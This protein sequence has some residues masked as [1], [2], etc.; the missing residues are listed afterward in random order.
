[1]EWWQLPGPASFVAKITNDLRDGKN[2]LVCLPN[3]VPNG[4]RAIIQSKLD[5]DI[6]WR[7][8]FI[9]TLDNASPMD[10]LHDLF[11]PTLPPHELRNISSLLECSTFMGQVL[12]LNEIKSRQWQAWGDFIVKYAHACRG[13]DLLSRT[14][15]CII[16]SCSKLISIPQEDVCLAIRKYQ[17][18]VT[19]LDVH[20]FTRSLNKAIQ[21]DILYELK[22]EIVA[23]LAQWDSKLAEG[24]MDRE[25]E[26][27]LGSFAFLQQE[28][29]LR[30]WDGEVPDSPEEAWACGK[31]YRINGK[32]ELHSC[33]CSILKPDE[34]RHRIWRAQLRVLYPY[35]EEQ[36]QVL[37]EYL[38][39]YLYVPYTTRFGEIIKDIKDLE[40]GHIE[41]IMNSNR[42][43]VERIRTLRKIRN[44][45]AHMDIVS[46]SLLNSD[47]V[48]KPLR[49]TETGITQ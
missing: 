48:R 15:F 34:L 18:A 3:H 14:V 25:L 43:I 2:V 38:K 39:P 49:L 9:G 37:L 7:N 19:L 23:S 47:A 28:A 17:D 13:V 36:R 10:W 26:E 41:S 32:D 12:C 21:T 42:P 29:R 30:N 35:V 5:R 44:D 46:Y 11:M 22:L 16:L 45:L 4:L 31:S 1:M 40:I 27:L 20:L 33:I 8:L 6:P 24:L